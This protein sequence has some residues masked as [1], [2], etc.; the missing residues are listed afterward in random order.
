MAPLPN[1]LLVALSIKTTTLDNYAY[2]LPATPIRARLFSLIDEFWEIIDI[3]EV[4][5]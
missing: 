5:A 2:H 4:N 3:L 1:P